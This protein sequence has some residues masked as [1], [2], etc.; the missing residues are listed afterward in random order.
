MVVNRINRPP[1]MAS[2]VNWFALWVVKGRPK[3][4]GL[5][6]SLSFSQRVARGEVRFD[7][8]HYYESQ[9]LSTHD[10]AKLLSA[11]PCST[12]ENQRTL[13]DP[14]SMLGAFDPHLS[15]VLER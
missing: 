9:H 7:A 6:W 1:L 3:L 13:H 2:K 11:D 15:S 4:S 5:S 10:R 8:S 12:S 14:R